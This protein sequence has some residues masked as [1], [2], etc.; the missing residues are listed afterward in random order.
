MTYP[1]PPSQEQ[2]LLAQHPESMEHAPAT[3]ALTAAPATEAHAAAENGHE[4]PTAWAFYGY[5]MGAFFCIIVLAIIGGR[6]L[7]LRPSKRQNVAEFMVETLYG[8]PEMVMGTRGRQYAPFVG[9]LFLAV[10][11]MNLLGLVP[12]MRSGSANLSITAGLALVAFFAVQYYGFRA[13]GIKYLA[14]FMGP[15]GINT[16]F[17]FVFGIML[18]P[19]ELL[20]EMIRPVSLSFRLYG[21][22]FGEEQVVEALAKQ[23]SPAAAVLMLPLQVMT[24][25]LQALVFALLVTVYI[26]LATEGHDESHEE[27]GGEDVASVPSHSH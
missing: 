25:V 20:A 11:F 21:N 4:G 26:A 22:I 27:H 1:T 15:Q 16:V 5:A 9:T 23:M 3:H 6:K 14:H 7:A 19:L 13:H 8:I 10:L 17:G 2:I 18:L 12:I 24:S